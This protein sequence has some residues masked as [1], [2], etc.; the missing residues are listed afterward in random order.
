MRRFDPA[1]LLAGL[2]FGVVAVL[3]VISGLSDGV[4]PVPVVWLVP[5]LLI[6]LGLVGITRAVFRRRD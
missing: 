1:A 3:Y 5:A 6:G 2:L 4:S